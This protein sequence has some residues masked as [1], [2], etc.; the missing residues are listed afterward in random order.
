VLCL[1]LAAAIVGGEAAHAATSA[2]AAKV[3]PA[4]KLPPTVQV[5]QTSSDLRQTLTPVGQL[6]FRSKQPTTAHVIHVA[7]SVRYQRIVGVG[8]AMTDTS[9]WLL[10]TQLPGHVF[11]GT[12]DALFGPNGIHLG[13]IRVPMGAS[14]F[15]AQEYPYSYDDLNLVPG[16]SDPSLQDFSIGHDRPYIL[17]ALREALKLN[18]AAQIIATPWSPPWWMKSNQNSGN[19]GDTGTLL[20]RITGCWRTTSSSFCR[21]THAKRCRLPPSPRRTNR[22]ARAAG[23]PG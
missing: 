9:A 15:T 11:R 7:D 19:A 6:Q 23:I 17:P 13:F 20:P 2:P 3:A 12:M 4:V 18:P 5:V 8:G 10:Y 14:D 21:P 16:Q 1:L 22:P